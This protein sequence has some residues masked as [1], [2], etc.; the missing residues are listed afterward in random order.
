MFKPLLN[1]TN[2]AGS[3]SF[4]VHWRQDVGRR[5]RTFH[6]RENEVL[7]PGGSDVARRRL[8]GRYAKRIERSAEDGS[9]IPR[10]M[11]ET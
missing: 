9:A 6:D 4:G 8:P 2:G 5:E 10:I 7:T 1:V 3:S 11:E